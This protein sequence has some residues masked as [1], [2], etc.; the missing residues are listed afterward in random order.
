MTFLNFTSYTDHFPADFSL[1]SAL[2]HLSDWIEETLVTSWNNRVVTNLNQKTQFIS[3]I[4][5]AFGALS[6]VVSIAHSCIKYCSQPK[7]QSPIAKIPPFFVLLGALKHLSCPTKVPGYVRVRII[8]DEILPLQMNLI[9]QE[10]EEEEIKKWASS[11]LEAIIEKLD[12]YIFQLG[13]TK[14]SDVYK[15]I[16]ALIDFDPDLQGQLKTSLLKLNYIDKSERAFPIRKNLQLCLQ[17]FTEQEATPY[18][19]MIESCL[20]QLSNSLLENRLYDPKEIEAL[21]LLDSQL[22]CELNKKNCW[23][24]DFHLIAAKKAIQAYLHQQNKKEE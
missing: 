14:N 5:I 24:V 9:Y 2:S 1:S 4:L 19:D 16:N 13:T 23:F 20:K 6:L 11:T 17:A 8:R 3:Q 18:R 7:K 21:R 22:E 15:T 10:W 12:P